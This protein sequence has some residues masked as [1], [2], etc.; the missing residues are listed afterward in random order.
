MLKVEWS[1]LAKQS[2]QVCCTTGLPQTQQ[3]QDGGPPGLGYVNEYQSS[4]MIDG[5]P[6]FL[7]GW[8]GSQR[9]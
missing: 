9:A 3:V 4:L 1:E 8:R 5:H 2:V 6:M 7:P